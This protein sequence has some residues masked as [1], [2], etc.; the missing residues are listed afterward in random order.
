MH[1]HRWFSNRKLLHKILIPIFLQVAAVG[2]VLWTARTA[3]VDLTASTSRITDAVAGRL[4]VAL[5]VQSAMGAAMDAEANAIVAASPEAVDAASERLKSNL[6]QAMAAIDGLAAEDGSEADRENVQ[7]I[8]TTIGEY[9]R[10]AQK[11]LELARR[12]DADTAMRISIDVGRPVRQ[13]LTAALGKRV[14]QSMAETREAEEHAKAMSGRVMLR[15]YTVGGIGLLIA[16]GLLSSIVLV[17]VVRPLN[18]LTSEMA[19]IAGGDLTVEI[20]GADRRDEIGLLA[21]ALEIFKNNALDMRRLQAERNEQKSRAEADRRTAMLSLADQFDADVQGVVQAVALAAQQLQ[22]N[23]Q[24]MTGV[25]ALTMEKAS[26]VAAATEQ[27]STN[28]A[29]VAAASEQ[30]GS[31]IGDIG[32]Q[33]NGAASIARNAVAE[34]ER[35]NALVDRLVNAAQKIGAVVNLIH[36]IASQ[37]NLLALNATIEAA[38]AG[39]AGRGFAVVAQEVKALATQTAQA[40][41]EI[42]GQITEIQAVTDGTAKAIYNIGRTIADVD[43]IATT[44]AASVEEQTAATHEIARNIQQAAQGTQHVSGNIAGV[45]QAASDVRQAASEVLAA[46]DNLSDDSDRLRARIQSFIG[47]VR[48]A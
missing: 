10:V 35:T 28:V 46:A 32:R 27:A 38:R 44:V 43:A 23:A 12:F 16:F 18:R 3:I 9:E 14:E 8:K 15:L 21:R 20:R 39:E 42:A 6:V 40:T 30:L 48:A 41:E 34:G 5:A 13:K 24:A 17:F 1:L 7:I 25:A 22:S 19:T 33:V 36:S 4:G 31:S 2:G 11:V 47:Q 37:T 45:S 26:S 29:T